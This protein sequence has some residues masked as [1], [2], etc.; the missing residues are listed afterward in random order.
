VKNGPF[1][2]VQW[3]AV[4]EEEQASHAGRSVCLLLPIVMGSNQRRNLPITSP[5]RKEKLKR[6]NP[7]SKWREE[8]EIESHLYSPTHPCTQKR[9]REREQET[10]TQQK[11]VK[12]PRRSCSTN[13]DLGFEL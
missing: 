7:L 6:T 9:R 1:F 5:A 13:E 10:H 4:T 2:L 11:Y 3:P 12:I 8:R